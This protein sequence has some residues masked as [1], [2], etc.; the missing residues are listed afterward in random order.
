MHPLGN[1]DD[2]GLPRARR[3][4]AFQTRHGPGGRA[5]ITSVRFMP[6]HIRDHND[7]IGG[8]HEVI[9]DACFPEPCGDSAFQHPRPEGNRKV[10]GSAVMHTA[11]RDAGEPTPSHA[12][13]YVGSRCRVSAFAPSRPPQWATIPWARS[14][15]P[16]DQS[17]CLH[18][19]SH[20]QPHTRAWMPAQILNQSL[21]CGKGLHYPRTVRRLE[22]RRAPVPAQERGHKDA[23]I[24]LDRPNA[25]G[26]RAKRVSAGANL[27][28]PLAGKSRCPI[29]VHVDEYAQ[30][31]HVAIIDIERIEELAARRVPIDPYRATSVPGAK[32]NSIIDSRCTRR[33]GGDASTQ[34]YTLGRLY[35]T[36]KGDTG[37]ADGRE[38][39]RGHQRLNRRFRYPRE[40]KRSE[41]DG[42]EQE[43]ASHFLHTLP[44][45]SNADTDNG[46]RIGHA[47]QT[48]MRKGSTSV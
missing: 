33:E 29:P 20:H 14:T 12:Y 8:S 38:L 41:N 3:G 18:R 31:A 22:M 45:P 30:Q 36:V 47:L 26:R 35:L 7:P 34:R 24:G 1:H 16:Q 46:A 23:W 5:S 25:K 6:A 48:D 17:W 39:C 42:D 10:P 21:A 19:V 9:H 2:P 15:A 44:D 4:L 37:D 27:Y 43:A 32:D 40:P 28:V 13:I 11:K